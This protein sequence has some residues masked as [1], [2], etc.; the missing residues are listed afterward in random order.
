MS[1]GVNQV[2]PDSGLRIML[3]FRTL[4][5]IAIVCPEKESK[6]SKVARK[7]IGLFIVGICVSSSLTLKGSL[8]D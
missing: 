7:I 4:L 3:P 2:L 1:T 8:T 6:L 5:A